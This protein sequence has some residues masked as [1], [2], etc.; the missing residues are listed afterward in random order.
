MNELTK[1]LNLD[2]VE[3]LA[4]ESRAEVFSDIPAELLAAPVGRDLRR[5]FPKQ[6]VWRHQAMSLESLISGQNTV[7]ATGTA[8]G[9]SLVFQ[10]Y[11]LHL[12]KRDPSAR[13]LVFYP[14]KALASD[15][16]ARWR[17][18]SVECGLSEDAVARIDGEVLPAERDEA[19]AKA[20]IVLM[21]PDVCQAWL[22][23]NVGSGMVRRFL[24]HLSLLVLDEAHVYESVFGSNVAFLLRRLINAKKHIARGVSGN[25]GVQI[26]AATATIAD[27]AEHL[28]RLTGQPFK[29][30]ED[31]VSGAPHHRRVLVHVA[32]ADYGAAGEAALTDLLRGVLALPQR[33]RFIAFIDSRQGTE[34]VVRSLESEHVLP[35]RSG[36]EADDRAKI[37][38]ALRDGSLHGVVSTSALELGIDIP[39]MEIGVNLGVPDTRKAFRQRIGR[40]GRATEGMFL[41]IAGQNAFRQ[42]GQTFEDYLNDSVEPSYL[43]TGNRFIQ[44][45]NARC[46]WDEME[47]MK[48][49]RAPLLSST[50]WPEGFEAILSHA[51]PG[52]ARPREFDFIAQLGSDNPHLNYP[53][54]Q[55]GE[56]NFEI[57]LGRNDQSRRVGNIAANQALREAYPGANYLHLGQSYKVHQWVA[58][59]FERS[60]RV[61]YSKSHVPTKA[62]LRKTVNMALDHLSVIDS[63]IRRNE[64]GLIAEANLQVNESVEGYRIGSTTFLYRDLRAENPNMSRKQRDIRTTGAVIMIDE[65]WF[66]GSTLNGAAN[67][68]AF[69]R[70]LVGVLARERSISP[71]DIDYAATNIALMTDN[72]PK[73]VSNCIVIYDAVYGGI[74]LTEDLFDRFDDYLEQILKAAELAGGDAIVST[75]LATVLLS[76]SQHLEDG[77]AFETEL[78]SSP[79]GWYQV[80]RPGSI[81]STYHNGQL[82]ARE[83]VSPKL[84]DVLGDGNK[85]L[86]YSYKLGGKQAVIPHDQVHVAGEEWSYVLWNPETNE[87]REL[88]LEVADENAEQG[89]ARWIR[90]YR[91]GTGIEVSWYDKKVAREIIEPRVVRGRMGSDDTIEY[92]YIENGGYGYIP[93]ANVQPT[94]PD[95][96]LVLWNPDT[97]EFREL[98]S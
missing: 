32:G 92:A 28:E 86:F 13:V 12:L 89:Q 34:R 53:L 66:A 1:Q 73:R 70:A 19:L 75:D 52:S 18:L 15:Q 46:L 85:T 72:G 4:L 87:Y 37:E 3:Q 63:R 20:N 95:W 47:V 24:S 35:Y 33:K 48:Q 60:I 82:V 69:G 67:R 50:S 11:S 77:D 84:L 41:L 6:A 90:V 36:Y 42:F 26:V 40:V 30:I 62:I 88:E 98:D 22:M 94:G 10:T 56:A 81:V 58:S 83:L 78:L 93:H 7:V 76:W 79:D 2:V 38:R 9:K 5:M 57:K 64:K 27:P 54:R 55:I 68:D 80:Y 49:D 23:R 51:R 91:P 61:D 31:S 39:D 65:P 8:S 16:F 59:S 45:A 25:P 96:S 43:Y 14:L 17:K 97:N 44:F 74:R 71:Q 29:A 21:T